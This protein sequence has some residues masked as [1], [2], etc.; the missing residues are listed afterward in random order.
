MAFLTRLFARR[1]FPLPRFDLAPLAFE[2][3]NAGDKGETLPDRPLIASDAGSNVVALPASARTP[4]Q[5][6][7]SI[8]RHLRAGQDDG[9]LLEQEAVDEL[10]EALAELRRSLG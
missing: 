4:G 8:E 1:D 10:R 9:P 3:R 7:E 6:R 2:L 5:L